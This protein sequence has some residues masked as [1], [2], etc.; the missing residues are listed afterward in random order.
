M[1]FYI[2]TALNHHIVHCL[3]SYAQ[4]ISRTI[5]DQST[6]QLIHTQQVQKNMLSVNSRKCLKII[7]FN[8]L[9]NYRLYS[10]C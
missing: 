6:E 8:N 1:S 9:Q 10:K 3:I 2:T 7:H 4:Q 5:S